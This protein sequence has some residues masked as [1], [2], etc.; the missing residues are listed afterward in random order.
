MGRG[1]SPDDAAATAAAS[2]ASSATV[3]AAP[4]LAATE[5]PASAVAPTAAESEAKHPVAAKHGASRAATK[6]KVVVSAPVPEPSRPAVVTPAP[7]RE[8]FRPAPAPS[9]PNPAEACKDRV[10]LGRELCLEEACVK[11]GARNHPLCVEWRR[12]K[13]LRENS[14]IGN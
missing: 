10:F 11:P 12:D 6:A 2:A 13:Q 14:R 1:S 4:A 7:V 5:V 3:V 9:A 8:A